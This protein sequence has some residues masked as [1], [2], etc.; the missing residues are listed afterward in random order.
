MSKERWLIIIAGSVLGIL[1]VLLVYWGNPLNMG[2]CI[3]CFIRDITGSMGFHQ[4]EVVQYIRPEII[5]L[6][7]GAS[8]AAFVF[9]EFKSTGGSSPSLRLV[10]GAVMMIGALFFLGC[11]LRMLLRL[12]G[13]DLNALVGLPGYIFGIWI[14]VWFLKRGYTLGRSQE[15]KKANGLAGVFLAAFWL[16]LLLASPAFIH[17]S[18]EGPGAQ[19]AFWAISL[20]AGLL[21]GWLAQRSRLCT[22]GGIRDIIL[23]R[24]FH[25][26]YGIL[27]ILVFAL[28]GNLLTGYFE[29]GFIEQPVAHTDALW[30]F[31][32]LTIVGFAAVLAGG[33]PMRQLVLAGEGSSDA[34]ITVLG[35]VI[36]AAVAHNFGLAA[37]PEGLALNGQVALGICLVI[38]LLIGLGNTRRGSTI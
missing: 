7:I 15:L 34:F 24:D 27:F 28:V 21:T 36:G 17:I 20:V 4:A 12:A 1:S 23:F 19:Y 11:P 10:I 25:L 18:Q 33:C 32:G 9:R 8:A 29:P 13:G 38:L 3:A 14:G 26:F 6:I 2:Y 22:M 5:G 35:M 31:L 30:N 16:I 37:S